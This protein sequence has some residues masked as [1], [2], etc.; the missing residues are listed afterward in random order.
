MINSLQDRRHSKRSGRIH[1]PNGSDQNSP[2]GDININDDEDKHSVHI[3]N[4]ARVYL[5]DVA[6]HVL[7]LTEEID[8]LRA[9]TEN[10]INLV[11]QAPLYSPADREKRFL[12][13]SHPHR[14][15]LCVN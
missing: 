12:I 9:T 2:V 14:M 3:S 7:I 10:M 5:A 11:S 15:K 8:I 1:P 13:S 4:T 6:D